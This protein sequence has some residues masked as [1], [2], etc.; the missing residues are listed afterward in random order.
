AV[1]MAAVYS[2]RPR[3]STT[4]VTVRSGTREVSGSCRELH[5]DFHDRSAPERLLH[6]FLETFEGNLVAHQRSHGH[7]ARRG[8]AYRL[9]PVGARVERAAVHGEL[10]REHGIEIDGH[11]LG[12]DGHHADGAP[13]T[14]GV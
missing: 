13:H 2:R 5:E 6:A 14:H 1:G 11:G 12:V 3:G 9:F 10:A 4:G 8:Q 7:R